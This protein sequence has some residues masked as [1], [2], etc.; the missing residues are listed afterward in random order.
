MKSVKS[1]FY[2]YVYLDPRKKG[3]FIHGDYQLLTKEN[4]IKIKQ[5]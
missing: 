4:I 2:F 1:T 5:I 3:S